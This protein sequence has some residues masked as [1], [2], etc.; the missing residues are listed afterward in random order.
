MIGTW[1]AA[2]HHR[3]LA[4]FETMAA[5]RPPEEELMRPKGKAVI[6][7]DGITKQYQMGHTLIQALRGIDLVIAATNI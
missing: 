4:R 1:H 6:E 5:V 7:I 2:P 3:D